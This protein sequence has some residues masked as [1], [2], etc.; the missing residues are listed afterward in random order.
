MTH[1]PHTRR[2]A[3]PAL[4]ALLLAGCVSVPHVAPQVTQ[5]T[6]GTIGLAAADS[7]QV[8][9]RWWTAF[10]DPQLDRLVDMGLAGNPDL[11][12]AMA[13]V[14]AAQSAVSVQRAADLPQVNFNAQVPRQRYPDN[15]I[16]PPPLGGTAFWIPQIEVSL[17]WDL[18][19]FGRNKAAVRQTRASA[20]A[21]I[22]DAAAARLAISVSIAR[23]YVGLA[24]AEQ[25]ILVAN[26]FVATR[27]KSLALVQSRIDNKLASNFD[28]EQARTLLAEA[29]QA[30][31]RAL[32]QRETMIHALAALVGRGP[33]FYGQI[34]A[35]TLALANGP[36]V[37]DNLPA[38]LLGR[39]PDLL[40]GQAPHRCGSGRTGRGPRAVPAQYQHP[41]AGRDARA[42]S[43]Q[44]L[45]GKLGRI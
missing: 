28:L 30:Q 43:G 11:A 14:R 15:Y 26:G 21:S 35:P 18:D 1:A 29:Q 16:L 4:A 2:I 27:E 24:H 22:L 17:G 44:C 23:T 8:S 6:P 25:Q 5:L 39:R 20:E 31:T 10:G 3:F 33:D 32:A 38:D 34:T 9:D 36:A 45:Q 42:G 19:L 41:G 37:P 40:A 12:A 13:R 7:A